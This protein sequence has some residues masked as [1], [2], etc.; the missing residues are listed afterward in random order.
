MAVVVII[1]FT[2]CTFCL[3][4]KAVFIFHY[5]IHTFFAKAASLLP[6]LVRVSF[7]FAI[8][9]TTIKRSKFNSFPQLLPHIAKAG[10]HRHLLHQLPQHS[11]SYEKIHLQNHLICIMRVCRA[12][13]G[14]MGMNDRGFQ[15]WKKAL[16]RLNQHKNIGGD[17]CNHI[18]NTTKQQ[19]LPVNLSGMDNWTPKKLRVRGCIKFT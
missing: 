18:K 1:M 12:T 3:L 16:S 2:N 4:N 17:L 10:Y 9:T 19:R 8:K 13:K 7:G 14:D 15:G 6:Y 11:E 5:Q